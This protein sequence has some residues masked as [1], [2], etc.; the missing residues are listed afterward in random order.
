MRIGLAYDLKSAVEGHLAVEDA[1]EEGDW[2]LI[3]GSRRMGMER[4]V[5]GLIKRLGKA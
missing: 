3:K 2:I 5:Q 4:I 1:L